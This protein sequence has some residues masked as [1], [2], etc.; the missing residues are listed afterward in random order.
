MTEASSII[1]VYA[2]SSDSTLL[3]GLGKAICVITADVFLLAGYDD[4]GRVLT[5]NTFGMGYKSRDLSAMEAVFQN[6]SFTRLLKKVTTVFVAADK[7]ML[8]PQSLFA[9]PDAEQWMAKLYFPEEEDILLTAKM[10]DDR[11]QHLFFIPKELKGLLERYL[12]KPKML[13]LSSYQF[14]KNVN[15]GN[16]VQCCLT[17]THAFATVYHDKQ[18]AWHRAFAYA[19]AEDIVYTIKLALREYGIEEGNFAVEFTVCDKRQAVT[20]HN[21]TKYFPALEDG[22]KRVERP[23]ERT[24]VIYLLQQLYT[25]V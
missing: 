3:D 21:L 22:S 16:L 20:V 5:I 9:K 12:D 18:L 4:K 11:T 1:D 10:K 25:C 6:K 8:V 19:N 2:S 17:G 14:H 23:G 24:G 7:Y 13:P 15:T